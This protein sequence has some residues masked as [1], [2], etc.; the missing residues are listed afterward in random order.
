MDPFIESVEQWNV[1]YATLATACAALVGL[2]FVALS[3]NMETLSREENAGLMRVARKTFGDFLLVFMTSLIFLVPNLPPVGLAV[4]LGFLGLSW[5]AETAR[6]LAR[7]RKSSAEQVQ[8]RHIVR[9]YGLSLASGIGLTVV[10]IAMLFELTGALYAL[11]AP[12]AG[13]IASACSTAWLLLTHAHR[14]AL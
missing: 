6:L 13:L 12:L 10:A 8:V 11:V 9:R 4:A 3:L 1:F 7:A 2:L 14:A 5:T